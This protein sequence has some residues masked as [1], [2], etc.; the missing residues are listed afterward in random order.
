RERWL[1]QIRAGKPFENPAA[2]LRTHLLV[3]RLTARNGSAIDSKQ[4]LHARHEKASRRRRRS[5]STFETITRRGRP[6]D[7]SK[8]GALLLLEQV[9]Q[10]TPRPRVEL[11]KP[12]MALGTERFDC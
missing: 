12:R 8:R 7:D 3:A 9:K 1:Q 10:A 2:R 11:R 5:V 4:L 6:D